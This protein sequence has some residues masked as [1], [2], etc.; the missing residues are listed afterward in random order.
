M[1]LR[2]RCSMLSTRCW[3][4]SHDRYVPTLA[5]GNLFPNSGKSFP[6]FGRYQGYLS[7]GLRLDDF[8]F[9]N[10]FPIFNN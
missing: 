4:L 7:R 1:C 10:N 3:R 5:R 8:Y 9:V 2:V 6:T